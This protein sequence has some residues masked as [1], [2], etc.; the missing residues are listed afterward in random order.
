MYMYMYIVHVQRI[1]VTHVNLHRM[2]STCMSYASAC[3][4][5]MYMYMCMCM[6]M[7]HVCTCKYSKCTLLHVGGVHS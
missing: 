2:I 6:C 7:Y 1:P 3:N 4:M 5:Y